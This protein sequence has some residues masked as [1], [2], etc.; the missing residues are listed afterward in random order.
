MADNKKYYYLKL[1]EN[2]FE[3]DEAII[4]ESMPDGYIYSNILLQAIFKKF[5]K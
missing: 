5:K 4:L 3:S 2:F 1:K